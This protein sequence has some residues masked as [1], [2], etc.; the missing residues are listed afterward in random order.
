MMAY[1]EGLLFFL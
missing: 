1:S